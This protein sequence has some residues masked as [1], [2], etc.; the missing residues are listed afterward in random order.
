M[1]KYSYYLI[2]I[3]VIILST[4]FLAGGIMTV[5]SEREIFYLFSGP[6]LSLSIILSFID[7]FGLAI[8]ITVFTRIRNNKSF[9]N[10]LLY[11]LIIIIV[12]HLLLIL[13][14]SMALFFCPPRH[15]VS[16]IIRE[17]Q[18]IKFF[19]KDAI[20]YLY[21]QWLYNFC[22]QARQVIPL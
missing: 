6:A 11:F 10:I 22:P 16:E 12:I 9:P 17:L 13:L 19:S 4:I 15:V 3:S 7:I 18:H 14:F 20:Y 8:G 2:S 1:K 21:G 5:L